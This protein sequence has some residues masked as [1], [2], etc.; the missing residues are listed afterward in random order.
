MINLRA[1][2]FFLDEAG[3]KWVR[4]KLAAMTDEEKVGQERSRKAFLT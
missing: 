3:E 4:E 1:K 2:P